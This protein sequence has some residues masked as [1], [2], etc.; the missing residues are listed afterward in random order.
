M[1][2]ILYVGALWAG[3]T[4]AQRKQA[5]C[6]LGHH[7][8]GIDTEPPPVRSVERQF[9]YRVQYRLLKTGLV[10]NYR[11]VPDRA[12]ANSQIVERIHDEQFNVL[13][14]D[15]GL[16]IS[17]A[18]L[19]E[20]KRLF[21]QCMIA[22]YCCDD[23]LNPGNQSPQFLEHLPM[24]DAFFTTK[25][26]NVEELRAL[27]CRHPLLTGNSYDPATHRPMAVS[28]VEREAYG[29]E[30]GFIGA[31]EAE[32]AET[33]Y[34][35]ATSGI[36]IRIW[37]GGW[38]R[39]RA[40]HERLLIEERQLWAEQYTKAICSFDIC[41]GFLNKKNRDLQTSRSIEIPA[42]QAFLLAE[43]T[44]EHS[45]LFEEGIEAEF[46]GSNEELLRKI[47]YYLAHPVERLRIAASGRERCLRSRYST[48]DQLEDML[49]RLCR[50]GRGGALK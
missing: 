34:Y 2:S 41:L 28:P 7:V 30:V 18:T 50:I 31:W 27:G 42:C 44:S 35:L 39:M 33:L 14:L 37:G 11:G 16:T 38:Q 20:V 8:L 23:V 22:G 29:G 12:R 19:V 1:L 6:D 3:S 40:E 10:P 21:P 5:L 26:Y 17:T 46:F 49:A 48:R 9:L 24:Y 13:W 4:S 36:R 32:R 47:K 25:S 43:R 45:A 15:K